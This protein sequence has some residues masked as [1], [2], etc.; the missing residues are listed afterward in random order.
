MLLLWLFLTL[1]EHIA[2]AFE[3]APKGDS[4]LGQFSQVR[5]RLLDTTDNDGIALPIRFP[6]HALPD[7]V[8]G[9]DLAPFDPVFLV[10]GAD[11]LVGDIVP[12]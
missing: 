9:L 8:L 2:R 11:E 10:Q 3:Q 6:G 1:Q 4:G 7:N 5:L 12:F